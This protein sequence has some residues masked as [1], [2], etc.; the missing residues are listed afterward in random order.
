MDTAKIKENSALEQQQRAMEKK[1]REYKRMAEG[2]QKPALVKEYKR[3]TAEAQKELRGFIAEHDDV[4]RRDYW[5]EKTYNV[6]IENSREDAIL[7]TDIRND[8][9]LTID[10]GK[11]GKHIL[12]HNNYTP[13]RSYLTVLE[14]E[15]QQLV[16]QYAGTGELLRDSNNRWKQTELVE[17]G[18][19]IGVAIK[20]DG[21]EIPT[22]RFIIHYSQS[23]THIVPTTRKVT[24]K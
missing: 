13:G 4:L 3:K 16:N 22:S 7:K 1:I 12:G 24:P 5:R 18:K 9:V 23:G 2:F 10:S 17:S 19:S 11:Q 6:P 15:A 20:M 21:A 8:S 14:D